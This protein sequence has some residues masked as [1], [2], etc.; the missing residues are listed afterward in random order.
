MGMAEA[1]DGLLLGLGAPLGLQ[2]ADE[3]VGMGP[4]H[5][6]KGIA[7]PWGGGGW[8]GGLSMAP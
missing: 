1:L 2:A 4:R 7:A 6:G 8:R 3:D 5:W